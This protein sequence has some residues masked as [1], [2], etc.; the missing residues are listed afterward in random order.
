MTS[1]TEADRGLL[2]RYLTAKD[3]QARLWDKFQA[4]RHAGGPV[5]ALRRQ[6][7]EAGAELAAMRAT[8]GEPDQH[9]PMCCQRYS[10]LHHPAHSLAGCRWYG[11]ESATEDEI[12]QLRE[13]AREAGNSA[14]ALRCSYALEGDSAALAELSKIIEQ[15]REAKS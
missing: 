10:R 14:L 7:D 11:Y 2:A 4:A 1:I 12:K 6:Y 15:A 13:D 3:E 8:L 9:D 5:A